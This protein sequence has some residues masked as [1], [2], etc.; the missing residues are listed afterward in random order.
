MDKLPAGAFASHETDLLRS[1][2]PTE[3]AAIVQRTSGP[4]DV[5]ERQRS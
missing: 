1:R 5:V 3:N 2:P 4:V